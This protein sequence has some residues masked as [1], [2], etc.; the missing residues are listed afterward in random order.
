MLKEEEAAACL[1]GTQTNGDTKK[2]KEDDRSSS[3]DD[4]SIALP[5]RDQWSSK[6]EFM[7]SVIGFAVGLGNVWRFPYLCYKNGGGEL[8][9]STVS[10]FSKINSRPFELNSVKTTHSANVPIDLHTIHHTWS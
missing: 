8:L 7:L 1:N 5:D 4:L 6:A 10:L 2:P 3:R 9:R